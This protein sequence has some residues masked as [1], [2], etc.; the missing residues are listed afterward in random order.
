MIKVTLATGGMAL[1]ILLLAAATPGAQDPAPRNAREGNPAG[2]APSGQALFR[3]RCAECHGADAKGVTGHDLTRLWAS[4][5]TDERVFQ[6]IRT[7]VPNTIMPSSSA[8]D[9]ELSALVALPAQSERCR[10]FRSRE[11]QHRERRAD[12]LVDVRKLSCGRRPRRPPRSGLVADWTTP[13]ARGADAGDSGSEGVGRGPATSRSRWSPATD[14]ESA[15][16]RRAKTRSR[17]RSWTRTSSS[18]AT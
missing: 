8:P 17:F 5:A 9:V 15:A 13:V 12:L 2:Q 3:E 7:G 11:G 18:R 10:A 14:S 16:Q 6:T 4:G 1:A